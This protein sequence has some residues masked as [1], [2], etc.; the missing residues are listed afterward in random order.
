MSKARYTTGPRRHASFEFAAISFGVGASGLICS[1]Q[2]GDNAT[3]VLGLE[4]Y[5][6]AALPSSGGR[7]IGF[8]FLLHFGAVPQAVNLHVLVNGVVVPQFN[9]T[10]PALGNRASIYPAAPV[11]FAAGPNNY[12]NVSFDSAAGIAGNTRPGGIVL[13]EY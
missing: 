9:V 3:V 12:L 4:F 8:E 11:P 1:V 10:I 5:S 6:S 13:V 7:L 2:N